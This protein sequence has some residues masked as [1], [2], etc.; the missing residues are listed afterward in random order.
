MRP[1]FFPSST[2]FSFFHISFPFFL[3]DYSGSC[4][5]LRHSFCPS[6]PWRF[7]ISLCSG[8]LL[9]WGG[10]SLFFMVL[11]YF[12]EMKLKLHDFGWNSMSRV[13]YCHFSLCSARC[14]C[15][16]SQP[17]F[18]TDNT[19]LCQDFPSTC[20]LHVKASIHSPFSWIKLVVMDQSSINLT[21]AIPSKSLLSLRQTALS[22]KCKTASISSEGAGLIYILMHPKET[23]LFIF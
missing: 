19:S 11:S 12:M 20:H 23:M 7:W 1:T 3:H 13:W 2:N 14:F 4:V 10:P 22:H 8:C 18:R 21:T 6:A 16:L 17:I 5:V 15:V 9:S